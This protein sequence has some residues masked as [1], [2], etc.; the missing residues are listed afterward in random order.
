MEGKLIREAK[1]VKI[2]GGCAKEDGEDGKEVEGWKKELG[3]GGGKGEGRCV[4][5]RK[6]GVG[7]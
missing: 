2:K 4:S 3:R 5:G 1:G 7:G 6:E